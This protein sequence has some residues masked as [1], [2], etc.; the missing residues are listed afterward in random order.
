VTTARAPGRA[1]VVTWVVFVATV[2]QLVVATFATGLPQFEDKGFGA[3]LVAYPL[4]MLLVP[5]VWVTRRGRRGGTAALPWAGFALLM[6][7]F[8]VDV[9]GNTFDLYD[10]LGWWDDANHLVNWFLL[11]TG[12]G[13]L[14]RRAD[15]R[16]AWLLALVVS[17]IGALLAIGWELGEWYTFIRQGTEL[18]TAYEDTLGDEALGVLG[19]VLAGLLVARLDARAR[20]AYCDDLERQIAAGIV[21]ERTMYLMNAASAARLQS[22]ARTPLVCGPIDVVTVCVTSAS[23]EPWRTAAVLAP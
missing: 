15:V 19:A 14:L 18:G 5:A 16:P 3:R 1:L 2:A 8:L 13:L 12:A 9:T 7:P 4:L 21:D 23:Y 22:A 6:L 10:R 17:G 11:C 20:A